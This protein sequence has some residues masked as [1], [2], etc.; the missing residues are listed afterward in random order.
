[1]IMKHRYYTN[2][3]LLLL[4]A[5]ATFNKGGMNTGLVGGMLKCIIYN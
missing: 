5:G 4:L 1:M 2:D 3:Q